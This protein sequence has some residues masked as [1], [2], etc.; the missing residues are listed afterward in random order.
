MHKKFIIHSHESMRINIASG[1]HKFSNLMQK[2]FED[3][4][5]ECQLK[6]H[7]TRQIVRAR[8]D[9]NYHIF[10]INGAQGPRA[11]N[12]RKSFYNPFWTIEKPNTRHWGRIA[13]KA[14]N[15]QIVGP[16]LATPFFKRMKRNHIEAGH[17]QA[18]YVGHV[19]IP[20]QGKLC[21]KRPWQF[22]DLATMVQTI[23]TNDP[24]RHII[25]KPHPREVYSQAELSLVKALAHQPNVEV[26]DAPIHALLSG[27]AYVATQ[28]SA[29]AFEGILLRKPAIL[30]AQAHYHHLF[31]VIRKPED[32]AEAFARVKAENFPF[33]K[34]L[35]WY[36]HMNSINVRH[37]TASAKI[38][39]VFYESGWNLP[40]LPCN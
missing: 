34:Y 19:L 9:Q 27:C 11:L 6:D 38:S 33:E 25:L 30:F 26:V 28:N 14:F 21:K 23:R 36:L 31:P 13:H 22:A 40:F 7:T 18:E 16:G 12:M 24:D 15:P 37:P 10:H 2:L 3:I 39:E 1:Q 5:F 8:I 35:Y 17:E 4:G 20:M 29:V 32:A